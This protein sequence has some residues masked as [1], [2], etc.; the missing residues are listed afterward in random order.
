MLKIFESAT[1]KLTGWYLLILMVTTTLFSVIIYRMSTLE[2]SGRLESLELRLEDD[3]SWPFYAQNLHN[4]RVNQEREAEQA[5]LLGL[6]YTNLAIWVLGGVGSYWLAR[7]TLRPI[8]EMH[9]AQSRFTS[10][11]SHELKTPL[12]VMKSELELALR[13]GTLKKNDYKEVIGSSLEEVNKLTELTHGLLQMSRLDHGS[14][15]LDENVDISHELQRVIT[16]LDVNKRVKFTLPKQPVIHI[17]NSSMLRDV[18]MITLDNAL[19]Y[20]PTKSTVEVVLKKSS[21]TY[22]S[23]RNTGKGIDAKHIQHIFDRFYQA[24][25]SRTSHN[26]TKSYGLGLSV[27]KKIID[28]HKG[29]IVV[30]SKPD[31]HTIVKITLPKSS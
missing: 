3:P 1:L 12:A 28:L 16:L 29:E 26:G 19:R 20:S 13:D 27:A 5:I 30:T 9:E 8:Q 31:S 18:F 21:K 10:D 4:A 6:L 2:L 23:I 11:A 15:P 24:D 14:I 25:S 22:V 7:R 17:G